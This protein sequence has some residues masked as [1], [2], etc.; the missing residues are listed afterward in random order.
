MGGVKATAE[1]TH[2]TTSSTSPSTPFQGF[3][4]T[5]VNLLPERNVAVADSA[6]RVRHHQAQ[7]RLVSSEELSSLVALWK[8]RRH[9]SYVNFQ[10]K[11]RER[12][13]YSLTKHH[14]PAESTL[15]E[16]VNGTHALLMDTTAEVR[17]CKRRNQ[18]VSALRLFRLHCTICNRH[19]VR[20]NNF[21][22]VP[23]TQSK[24]PSPGRAAKRTS[25]EVD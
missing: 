22:S 18:K 5:R 21:I 11:G 16:P 4:A 19:V 25:P 2:F 23:A 12:Q 20:R 15:S 7:A 8:Q 9:N 24:P 17:A 13:A 3:S 10:R 14:T 1:H 6:S